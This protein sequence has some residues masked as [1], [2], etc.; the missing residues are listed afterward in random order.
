MCILEPRVFEDRRGFFFESYNDRAL[1]RWASP[2]VLCRTTTRVPAAGTLRG[3]HYQVDP[4][5]VK[6][7]RVVVG[8]VYDVAV[9]V[10]L[11]LAHLRAVGGRR[12]LGRE[13]APALCPRGLCPRLLRAQRDVAEFLYKVT[14]YYSPQDERGVLWDDPDLAIAWPVSDADPVGQGSA[15]A[16]ACAISPATLSGDG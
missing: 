11:G 8:E 14:S 5:Q 1:A 7:V 3:L 13:Q 16:P 2:I 4:G 6:L 12:A 10:A 9:D 15:T